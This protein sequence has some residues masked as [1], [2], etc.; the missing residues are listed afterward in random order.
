MIGSTL[1]PFSV[2]NRKNTFVYR[3]Q[4]GNVFY[5]RLSES[6]HTRTKSSCLVLRVYGMTAPSQEITLQLYQ[7]LENKVVA[8]TLAIISNLLI[9]NPLLKLTDE[10]V[11]FLRPERSMPVCHM[12]LYL[13]AFVL[14]ELPLFMSFLRTNLLLFLSPLHRD[15]SAA[16]ASVNLS[17][18]SNA[19]GMSA[20]NVRILCAYFYTNTA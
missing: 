14:S 12:P 8:I 10:D 6:T 19:L 20:C 7:L 15:G 4:S 17:S 9:R 2:A 16:A 3:E 5:L 13:P 11:E 1:H 18:S